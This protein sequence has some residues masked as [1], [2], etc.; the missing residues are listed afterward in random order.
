[1]RLDKFLDSSIIQLESHSRRSLT[2]KGR[3]NLWIDIQFNPAHQRTQ[4]RIS[5]ALVGKRSE[6]DL[7]VK[8]RGRYDEGKAETGLR[9]RRR[10]RVASD[11]QCGTIRGNRDTT[12]LVW[13]C[14]ELGL[15]CEH[16]VDRSE[17]MSRNLLPLVELKVFSKCSVELE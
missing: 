17:R 5:K 8:D 6:P 2:G 16:S 3:V 13:F 7:P 15:E 10:I 9:S 1:M 14:P 12:N 11:F 4:L